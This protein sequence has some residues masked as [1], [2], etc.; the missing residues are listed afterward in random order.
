[1]RPLEVAARLDLLLLDIDEQIDRCARE[2]ELAS[3]R[4]EFAKRS[5]AASSEQLRQLEEERELLC[6]L[7]VAGAQLREAEDLARARAAILEIVVNLIGCETVGLFERVEASDRFVLTRSLG[8]E[9]TRVA[10]LQVG[11]GF[12]GERLA[13]SRPFIAEAEPQVSAD[14]SAHGLTVCLPLAVDDRVIAALLMYELLPQKSGLCLRDRELL[15]LLHM[16]AGPA[17]AQVQRTDDDAREPSTSWT[18]A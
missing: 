15:E 10:D 2:R 11:H 8:L 16:Y 18:Q 5:Q 4:L 13:R 12:I 1:M 17:L 6:N 14:E 9:R 3:N 7:W